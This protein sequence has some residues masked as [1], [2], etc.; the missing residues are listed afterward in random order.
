MGKSILYITSEKNSFLFDEFRERNGDNINF[1]LVNGL[2][3]IN[4]YGKLKLNFLETYDY[5]IYDRNAFKDDDYVFVAGLNEVAKYFEK[6]IILLW[7]GLDTNSDIFNKVLDTGINNIMLATEYREQKIEINEC[8]SKEGMKRYKT[9]KDN[10]EK[11]EIYE[12]KDGCFTI[13]SLNADRRM[14]NTVNM[15]AFANFLSKVGGLV[16]YV[17]FKSKDL[18]VVKK[19]YEENGHRIIKLNE[20]SDIEFKANNINFTEGVISD[21][22]SNIYILDMSNIPVGYLADEKY[23]DY[24]KNADRLLL[25]SELN[26]FQEQNAYSLF[27]KIKS[28]DPDIVMNKEKGFF[29][30]DINETKENFA[31]NS[32]LFDTF[33]YKNL[34]PIK[35]IFDI[36]VNRDIYYNLVETQINN[37]KQREV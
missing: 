13:V 16:N 19:M 20:A 34:R 33:S 11:A 18:L 4:Q 15:L 25:F 14:K 9:N 28:I 23:I 8:F 37:I 5:I 32:A 3:E 35:D 31:R 10:R 6:T 22:D 24:I 17:S 27:K 30:F 26:A 1:K 29:V 12:F 7:T 2:F 36:R 21:V